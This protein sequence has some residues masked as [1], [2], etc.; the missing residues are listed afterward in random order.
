[1]RKNNIALVL[2]AKS[3]IL[4]KVKTRLAFSV[5][6]ELA[7]E[8]YLAFLNDSLNQ[9]CQLNNVDCYL[10]LTDIW[11]ETLV[12]LP[13]ILQIKDINIAYQTSGDLGIKLS[14]TFLE[15]FAKKYKA[16]I[17]MGTDSPNLPI[18]YLQEAILKIINF[19]LVL[20]ETLDGGYYLIGLNQRVENLVDLFTNIS[21]STEKVF[22]ETITC[23]KKKSLEVFCLPSWYDIDTLKDLTKLKEDIKI[24]K[25]AKNCPNTAELLKK[26]TLKT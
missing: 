20:G 14:T 7:L 11:N 17:I 5:G 3:P 24:S 10:Y 8:F 12:K 15:L 4:G 19:D 26:I 25:S 21:W 22:L 13:N 2:F 6:E 1:M 9:V 18:E 23:A 16:V